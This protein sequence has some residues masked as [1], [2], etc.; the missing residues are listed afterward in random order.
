MPDPRFV[1]YVA[2]LFLVGA[3]LIRAIHVIHGVGPDRRRRDWLK[4]AIYMV[5]INGLWASAF[6]GRGVAGVVLGCIVVT[7]TLEIHRVARP[8]APAA[9][10][11]LP[12]FT[13]ALF[14]MLDWRTPGW[15]SHFAFVVVVTAS[16]DGFG[17]IVGRLIGRHRL[18]PRLS[19]GKTVEGL[20][21]GLVVAVLVAVATGFMTPWSEVGPLVIVGLVTSAGA[22]AGDLAFSAIKRRAGVKDFSGILPGHGGILDRFDSLLLAAPAFAL[23]RLLLAG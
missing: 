17:E 2:V 19:P 10:I 3:V 15:Q 14:P 12:L 13:A 4:Y 5:V 11:A 23:A 22:V 16:V 1:L 18:V 9:M 20:V 21:G 6:A 8:A 7:G